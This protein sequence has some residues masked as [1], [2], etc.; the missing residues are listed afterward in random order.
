[1]AKVSVI[2]PVYNAEKY[3]GEAIEPVLK[4]TYTEFELLLI[5]DRSTDHST[6]ICG[7]YTK[8]TAASSCWKTIRTS[9]APE[10]PEILGWS[11]PQESMSTV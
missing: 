2:I 11:T 3:L 4:Q 6:E 10:P 1:M 7:E 9:T 8:R 5:N